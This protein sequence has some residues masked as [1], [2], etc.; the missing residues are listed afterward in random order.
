MRKSMQGPLAHLVERAHG[1][2]EA[3]GSSPAWSTFV[4]GTMRR[5][6]VRISKVLYL[7]KSMYL[8]PTLYQKIVRPKFSIEKYIKNII[9]KEFILDT[10]K[11]LDFGC[12]TGSNSFIFNPQYYLGVDT[13][14]KRIDFAN[15]TFPEY[16]F[17]VIKNNT[18]PAQDNFFDY[19][20]IFATIHH[21][22]NNVFREYLKEFERV[23]KP[24]GKI[25]VIEPVLSK[26][27]KFNNWFMKTFDDG[28]YIR[29][30]EEYKK[31]FEEKFIITIHKRFRKFFFLQ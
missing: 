10:S 30:E 19:I 12:G 8:N 29:H 2:G 14:K 22:P 3:A 25:I 11:V 1:M 17:E 4:F 31:L 9:Q 24:N 23:I 28:K 26:E 16:R 21:I 5:L 15:K 6:G 13:D 27:H 18:L 7:Y 20:C